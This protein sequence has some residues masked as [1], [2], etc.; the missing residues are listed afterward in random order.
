MAKS[1][2]RDTGRES[3]PVLS[4]RSN[5]ASSYSCLS[6]PL[7]STS[8]TRVAK[9]SMPG[10]LF[11]PPPSNFQE[12][13]GSWPQKGD[14]SFR[15]TLSKTCRSDTSRECSSN[16]RIRPIRIF[17]TG[18]RPRGIDKA[19]RCRRIS[20]TNSLHRRPLLVFRPLRL[21]LSLTRI[22]RSYS[23]ACKWYGR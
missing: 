8:T 6:P 1:A 9:L 13:A 22:N 5:F 4:T 21:F 15:G 18:N 2:E 12:Q 23:L 11:R 10:R 17:P 7:S 14:W 3:Y 19:I 16:L 20:P